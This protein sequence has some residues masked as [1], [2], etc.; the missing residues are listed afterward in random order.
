MP[1]K[2]IRIEEANKLI[3]WGQKNN[4]QVGYQP[5][6]HKIWLKADELNIVG[7]RLP[8]QAVLN[9][10]EM[11]LTQKEKNW[12]LILVRAGIAS[13][14]YFEQGENRDHK[15]FRSYMV[16]KKQGKSQVKYLKTKGKSR[17]G[18]RVRLA[19]TELFFK[20]INEKV[21]EYLQNYH[22]DHVGLSIS[23]TLWPYL[24]N[25]KFEGGISKSDERLIRIPKHVQNPT[26]EN[27]L[28]VNQFMQKTEMIWEEE[29]SHLLMPFFELIKDDESDNDDW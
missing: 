20:D 3:T 24:F 29:V 17:A 4:Y 5:E 9:E 22:I 2:T 16:R 26:Y 25:S 7:I 12:I 11:T 13:T 1:K 27:L 14:G 15:V 6:K 10:K 18:S 21:N 23:K 8:F 28:A 19:S